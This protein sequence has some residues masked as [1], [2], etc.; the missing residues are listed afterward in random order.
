MKALVLISTMVLAA[1]ASTQSFTSHDPVSATPA[2]SIT[3]PQALL[4]LSLADGQLVLQDI[5]ID[6]DVCMKSNT[7]PATRCFK[8]GAPIYADD[9]STIIAYEAVA[10]ELDLHAAQ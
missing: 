4:L 6:A 1:C 3:T 9:A 7:A 10:R 5:D 2:A 8:R